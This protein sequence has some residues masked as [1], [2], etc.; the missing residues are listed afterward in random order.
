MQRT[1][2]TP[3]LGCF[4]CSGCFR[5]LL[6]WRLNNPCSI[7]ATR[8][9][10]DPGL[11]H[12]LGAEDVKLKLP[13]CPTP[14]TRQQRMRHR[15]CHCHSH[16]QIRRRL[17][18]QS[19][20]HKYRYI[21]IH[22]HMD[23]IHARQGAGRVP[24]VY[25]VLDS[26]DDAVIMGGLRLNLRHAWHGTLKVPQVQREG[27]D[28]RPR[29]WVEQPT[30]EQPQRQSVAD[31]WALTAGGAHIQHTISG[32]VIPASQYQGRP[33]IRAATAR[34]KDVVLGAIAQGCVS[35]LVQREDLAVSNNSIRPTGRLLSL[36][37]EDSCARG[38]VDCAHLL[39]SPN[40]KSDSLSTSATLC[41]RICCSTL[42]LSSSFC[43]LAMM[44]SASSFCWRCLTW[45]SYRTHESSTLL[46]SAASAVRCS[47]SYAWASSLAV[48]WRASQ[49]WVHLQPARRLAPQSPAGNPPW[50][51]RK[52]PWSRQ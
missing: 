13:C 48:S 39:L 11:W 17:C 19:A 6:S 52:G 23:F 27:T 36:G 43:T 7:G 42:G 46:A 51:P 20:G 49:P 8:D 21:H 40:P 30:P 5:A 31:P 50:T 41:C 4:A 16:F 22:A 47:S 28:H 33:S 35:T 1:K 14:L 44:L 18:V 9:T 45:L 2:K 12:L 29:H 38:L 10:L 3:G 34:R 25:Q 37:R 15:V 32:N 24:A 26:T